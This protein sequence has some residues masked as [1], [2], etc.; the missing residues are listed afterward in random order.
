MIVNINAYGI[1]YG[2]EAEVAKQTAWESG[3]KESSLSSRACGH[4]G[5]QAQ[6]YLFLKGS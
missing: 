3:I 5:R 2:K 1:R 6:Y 4:S